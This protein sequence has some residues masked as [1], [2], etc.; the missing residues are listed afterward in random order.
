MRP[1]TSLRPAFKGGDLPTASRRTEGYTLVELMFVVFIIALML[2]I[3]MPRLMPAMLSSQLEGAARHLAN[4]GRSA[5][6]YSALNHEPITVRFDLAKRE[7]YCLKWSEDDLAINSGMES[8]GLSSIKGKEGI[9]LSKDPD[10]TADGLST[11]QASEMT[12]QDI[13]ATGTA[14]DLEA[15]RDEVQFE[16]DNAF[17][18]SLIAQARNVP[19]EDLQG[20]VDPLF[21]KDFS[22]TV[23]GKEEQRDEIQDSLLEHG[24]LPDEIAIESILLGNEEITEGTVDVEVTPI[25]LSQS[26]SFFLKGP[27]DEYYTVQ[28][29]P[30]T[31]GAHL[32]RGKEMANAEPAF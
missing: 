14:E 12:I 10:K 21:E 5:I 30:I 18:R 27:K 15:Q 22:L 16:L 17:Q 26:V 13:I 19:H 8:A 9:G 31:G 7:Y 28:W 6:A 1:I 2:S 4:Y 3:A 11:G 23:E 32:M 24:Y 29:D 25:G 20:K